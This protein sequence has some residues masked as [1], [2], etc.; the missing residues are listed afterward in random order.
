MKMSHHQLFSFKPVDMNTGYQEPD[1]WIWCGSAIEEPG[2]GYHLFASRWSM[3]YPMFAGY[4]LS[5]EIVRAWSP[6]M[7]GPFTYQETIMPTG[8]HEQWHGR[9]SHNPRILRWGD[10]YVLYY[11]ALTYK[12]EEGP[13]I[14][15][16][17]LNV[18]YPRIRIGLA[19]APSPAGPWTA[20]PEPILNPVPGTWDEAIVTNPSP[21]VAPDGRIFMYYRSN[22]PK[23]LRIG[24]AIA[25]RPEGPYHRPVNRPVVDYHV[26]D[27]FVWHDGE[28][29]HM[30]AKDVDGD[31]SGQP[32]SGAHFVS[33]DGI[34]WTLSA[35]PQG[36]SRT[37]PLVGGGEMTLG[38]LERP[39]L[40]FNAEG[41]PVCLYGAV[42][43]GGIS[44]HH[45]TRS[46]NAAF[47]LQ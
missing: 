32:L 24:L 5:S 1:K 16:S 8:N 46:W 6:T 45:I 7:E 2:N 35:I 29:F 11:I 9:M 36:Y 10:R 22:T 3:S 4:L 23:G 20:L 15:R 43:T 21:C 25:E 47:P 18:I 12:D 40:L 26:E 13:S 28:Q 41:K 37:I 30:V 27:P 44:F 42:G 38:C 17:F 14:E 34:D 33:G 31:L 39:A 19:T